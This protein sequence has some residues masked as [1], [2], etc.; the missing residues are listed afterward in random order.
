MSM[1]QSVIGS[2]AGGTPP[3]TVEQTSIYFTNLVE[4]Q[5]QTVQFTFTNWDSTP[6]YW[7]ISGNGGANLSSQMD[8]DHGILYPGTGFS[9]QTIN[10]TFLADATTE[11][12]LYYYIYGGSIVGG[13]D[14]T[15]NGTYAVRDTSQTPALILDLDPAAISGGGNSWTDSSG[16]GNNAGIYS[17]TYSPNN[18]GT[19]V[20]SGSS[21]CEVTPL[22]SY[23]MSNLTF[24]IW[25]KPTAVTGSNQTLIAKELAYKLRI[26]TT[27]NLQFL[28][29]DG[30]TWQ[31][32]NTTAGGVNLTSGQWRLITVKVDTSTQIT[33][34]ADG[35]SVGNFAGTFVGSN[36]NPFDIGMWQTTGGPQDH[37]VGSI[38]EVKVWNYAISDSDINTYYQATRYRYAMP[39][40]LVFN[41]SS[42]LIDLTNNRANWALGTTWTIEYWSHANFYSTGTFLPILC[43]ETTDYSIDIGYTNQHLSF[44]NNQSSISEPIPGGWTHVAFVSNAG[45]VTVYYN[46]VSQGV[47]NGS[48]NITDS[49][50]DLFIGTRGAGGGYGQFFNGKLTQIHV[51]ST[52]SYSTTFVPPV[53]LTTSSDTILLIAPSTAAWSTPGYANTSTAI[54]LSADYPNPPTFGGTGT[55]GSSSNS[56]ILYT[57]TPSTNGIGNPGTAWPN[58]TITWEVTTSPADAGRTLYIW[59][60]N[61]LVSPSTWV[62]GSNNGTIT[63]DSS[64]YGRFTRT[65]VDNPPGHALFRMYVGR[66]LYSGFVTHGYIGV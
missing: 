65:V 54:T 15:S 27:G 43:Q 17:Y 6:F 51:N 22:N 19:I 50:N 59:V 24:G 32:T 64:G 1:M 47:V 49:G 25:M 61:D 52:A 34:Y 39:G 18:S 23:G 9:V 28:A 4:G 37:F 29:G 38:G 5:Q 7:T 2:T 31:S 41:G 16:A 12:T 3:K 63:L 8:H 46:G 13:S 66:A 44:G 36:S 14:Y 10:F 35:Q 20:L 58:D 62:E 53:A 21:S 45:T 48:S 11:G 33:I 40:S 56:G 60:D 55:P 42:S 57:L 30:Y 26:T